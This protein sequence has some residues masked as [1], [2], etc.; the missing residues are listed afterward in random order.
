MSGTDLGKTNGPAP[1]DQR[2]QY[3]YQAGLPVSMC[4]LLHLNKKYKK[5]DKT[6]L[7]SECSPSHSR[8]KFDKS[9]VA[10]YHRLRLR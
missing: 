5:W 2:D 7:E 6:L 3:E 4:K 9:F 10:T 1:Q 8:E